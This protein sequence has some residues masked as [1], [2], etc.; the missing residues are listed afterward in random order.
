MR[1]GTI[2]GR[3]FS[4]FLLFALLTFKGCVVPA[5][6]KKGEE[7]LAY[8]K[9]QDHLTI[10]FEYP[11]TKVDEKVT[12]S[13]HRRELNKEDDGEGDEWQQKFDRLKHENYEPSFIETMNEK[14]EEENIS[15][16]VSRGAQEKD[17][18]SELGNAYVGVV[19][20]LNLEVPA[21]PHRNRSYTD[22]TT[23]FW[24]KRK[25]ADEVKTVLQTHWFKSSGS[26]HPTNDRNHSK[27]DSKEDYFGSTAMEKN[28]ESYAKLISKE[29][30]S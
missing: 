21:V 25:G 6:V 16:K 3:A 28:A 19:K 7:N 12:E 13:E 1:K 29:V 11:N 17:N 22:V 27:K 26:D 5:K 20:V 10:R 23:E 14:F 24:I 4:F 8:L 9:N 15:L 30:G 2:L 18:E